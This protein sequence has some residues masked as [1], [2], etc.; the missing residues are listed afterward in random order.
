LIIMAA[1]HEV[2]LITYV[3]EYIDTYI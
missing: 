3:R 1:W 2:S